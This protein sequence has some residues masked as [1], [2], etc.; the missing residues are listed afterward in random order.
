[1]RIRKAAFLFLLA[2]ALAAFPALAQGKV[3][4]PKEFL[5]FNVGDDYL[6]ANYTQL[7]ATGRSWTGSPTA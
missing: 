1:M 3:T 4:S 5:G 6:L 2:I 7:L